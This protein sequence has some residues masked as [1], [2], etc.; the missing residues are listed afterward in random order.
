MNKVFFLNLI[1]ACFLAI[2]AK[3]VNAKKC[4]NCNKPTTAPPAA[5]TTTAAPATTTTTEGEEYTGY[6]PSIAALTSY[7]DVES[8]S[9]YC[10]NNAVS[11]YEEYVTNDYRY[12]I[13]SGA[14]NHAAEYAQE[15]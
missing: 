13:I 12:V 2:N 4:K 14:P 9:N 8:Q 5:P 3:K 6:G 7:D 11:Y 15:K 1:L 10:G